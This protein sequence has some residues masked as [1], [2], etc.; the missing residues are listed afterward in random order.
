MSDLSP[1]FMSPNTPSKGD[2]RRGTGDWESLPWTE[3]CCV[4]VLATP[5]NL[6]EGLDGLDEKYC[7]NNVSIIQ[8]PSSWMNLVDRVFCLIIFM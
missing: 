5:W 2:G 8:H 6:K 4:G 3:G 1:G 7:H